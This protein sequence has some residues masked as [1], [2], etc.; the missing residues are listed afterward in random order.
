M[1]YKFSKRSL[2]K[3]KTCDERLQKIFMEVI[4]HIDITILEGFRGKELQNLYYE[5]GKSKLKFPNGK[6]NKMPS[7]AVD[8]APYPIDWKDSA[9]FYYLAGFAKGVASQMGYKLRFGGDWDSDNDFKD[10]NF[11]D[12]PHF[13]IVETK[14]PR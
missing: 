8:V 13:E 12:L 9:R 1:S 3:L 7:L 10:Q 2:D 6:H 11:H 5:Q 4:K 14:K